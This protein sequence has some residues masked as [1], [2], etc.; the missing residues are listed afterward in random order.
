MNVLF[1]PNL[2]PSH[3]IPLVALARRAAQA[4]DIACAFLLSRKLHKFAAHL[5][6]R[7]LQV[8]RRMEEGLR[9]EMM[10]YAAFHPDVVVDDL[11]PTTGFFVRMMSL[12]RVSVIRKGLFPGDCYP[13]DYRHSSPAVEVF[14]AMRTL[15]LKA[16]SLWEPA[17]AADLF[18]GDVNLIPSVPE[19]EILPPA[20]NGSS[21]YR[22]VGPLLLNDTELMTN[23]NRVWERTASSGESLR[24]FDS[25]A[26][27]RGLETV[28]NDV[29]VFM[30]KSRPRRI[31]YFNIGIGYPAALFD[32]RLELIRAMLD[33]GAAVVSN[34]DT[35]GLE[36]QQR[37]R[38]F[39]APYLPM[40]LVCSKADLMVHQCGSGTYNY[41]IIHKCPAIILGS[42]CFD[43]DA[44]AMRLEE[45]GAATYIPAVDFAAGRVSAFSKALDELLDSES[46]RRQTQT[47]ML[48]ELRARLLEAQQRF[49]FA[50]L[51][52]DLVARFRARS[53]TISTNV[54]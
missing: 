49:D 53:A 22:Y 23:L 42:D 39:A 16:K 13:P 6:L 27:Q 33:T 9:P 30:E 10:A 51:L 40:H 2:M 43:R 20:L 35:P 14:G 29:A 17:D 25:G 48:C 21:R 31:V 1:V 46:K 37:E 34:I 54:L 5:G 50:S 18:V 38:F 47:Q 24:A 4:S 36:P 41:Q 52:R 12:P 11:S 32:N 45:V 15:N 7:V 3:F 8:D 28:T 26:P 19:L 44:V